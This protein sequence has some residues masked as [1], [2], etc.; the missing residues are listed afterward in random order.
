MSYLPTLA[1]PVSPTAPETIAIP[2]SSFLQAATYD[3]SQYN[4]TLEFKNGTTVFHR[5]VFPIVWSQFKESTSHGSFYARSIKKQYPSISFH[6]GLK[7]SDFTSA[8]KKHRGHPLRSNYAP[9]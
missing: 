2:H 1:M 7:V 4:L 6:A 3:A 9:N 5:F 8:V